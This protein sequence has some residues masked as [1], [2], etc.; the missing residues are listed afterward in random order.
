MVG[1]AGHQLAGGAVEH[2]LRAGQ[3]DRADFVLHLGG[4]R[5][6]R[7]GADVAPVH[8]EGAAPGGEQAARVADIQVELVGRAILG[9]SRL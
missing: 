5:V 9:A 4:G 7:Q 6:D 1:V 8:R 2:L 3:D